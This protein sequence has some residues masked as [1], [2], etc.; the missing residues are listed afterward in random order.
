MATF[1]HLSDEALQ[2][3]FRQHSV[4]GMIISLSLLASFLILYFYAD[5]SNPVVTTVSVIISA[6][7]V[8]LA[9]WYHVEKRKYVKEFKRRREA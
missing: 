5:P 7:S 3:R 8:A 9:I 1:N 4:R 2:T 6:A